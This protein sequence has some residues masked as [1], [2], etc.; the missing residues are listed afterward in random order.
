MDTKV[1]NY[2]K[3]ILT[4]LEDYSKIKPANWKSAHHQILAD[5]ENHHYQLVRFGWKDGL[6]EHYVIFH[7][8]IILGKVWVQQNNTDMDI[9]EELE[10]LGIPKK[11][12]VLA[13]FSPV[14]LPLEVQAA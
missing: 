1:K 7:F 6:R 14:E 8:D 3:A 5:K 11:S 9:L 13:C 12:I 10:F 4:L 2:E